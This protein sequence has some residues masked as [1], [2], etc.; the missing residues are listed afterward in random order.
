ME[1]C[2]LVG[3]GSKTLNNELARLQLDPQSKMG[4][5]SLS[6]D[7]PIPIEFVVGRSLH[8]DVIIRDVL[9]SRQHAFIQA[10]IEPDQTIRWF[11]RDNQSINGVFV[12]DQKIPPNTLFPLKN[13]DRLSLECKNSYQW[14]LKFQ[15]PPESSNG[16]RVRC[17]T[18]DTET[19]SGNS[20][21]KPE[22]KKAKIEQAQIPTQLLSEN[23]ENE[24]EADDNNGEE[25]PST[26]SKPVKPSHESNPSQNEPEP[27][28]ETISNPS[29][30]THEP[31]PGP[32]LSFKHQEKVDSKRVKEKEP[33]SSM[34]ENG[35]EPDRKTIPEATNEL[36]PKP[37]MSSKT[38]NGPS[39]SGS[40]NEPSTSGSTNEPEPGP[41]TNFR[42]PDTPD[43]EKAKV[44]IIPNQMQENEL[45]SRPS[46][47]SKTENGPSKPES[48]TEPEP[49]PSTSFK[50]KFSEELS[51]TI[52][53]ELFIKP[54][55]LPC[56]H[57][58]CAFCVLQWKKRCGSAMSCPNCRHKVGRDKIT[59]NIYVENLI[60]NFI[61]GFAD[62]M[63]AERER[64]IAERT[65][66]EQAAAQ[67]EAERE[68]NRAQTGRG[69]RRRGRGRGGAAATGRTIREMFD[70][71][72]PSSNQNETRRV[73]HP[74]DAENSSTAGNNVVDV[75]S[76]TDSDDSIISI[77]SV[78][79]ED[80]DSSVPGHPDAPYGGYGHCYGCGRRGHWL[81]GCLGL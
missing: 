3:C 2:V 29:N 4:P 59:P 17:P 81:P 26:S 31:E 50:A 11:T 24:S 36:K 60:T 45:K 43:S 58:F 37:S 49:G 41:S 42:G 21:E 30:N 28:V 22:P 20:R 7:Q 38:E 9:I 48:T 53:N 34:T 52:C 64:Q 51:C 39:T 1:R 67:A 13:G 55:T 14:K 72:G 6:R 19:E 18:N 23:D 65:A 57:V 33:T 75:E 61:Q 68:Q 77:G 76:D 69:Q 71:V 8:A 44:K 70:R 27:S 78:S 12:N 40:T 63:K 79:S 56:G 66:Q 15:R 25:E 16:K 10:R 35:L 46:T 74:T 32:S 47:S 62:D 54:K 73:A 5:S 80:S